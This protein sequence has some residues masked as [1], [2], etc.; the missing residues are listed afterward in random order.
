MHARA[1]R[2][3]GTLPRARA[4]PRDLHLPI[5]ALEGPCR[6]I[7]KLRRG[8]Q[9]DALSSD[10]SRLLTRRLHDFQRRHPRAAP[11]LRT[12]SSARN[13]E[14]GGTLIACA[15][16]TGW[17]D[18]YDVS[19]NVILSGLDRASH[20]DRIGPE[21]CAVPRVRRNKLRRIGG[22][23]RHS[24]LLTRSDRRGGHGDAAGG[25]LL[26][27]RRIER[28]PSR[29]CDGKK[30]AHDWRCTPPV[31]CRPISCDGIPINYR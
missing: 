19:T 3:A 12:V 1:A 29:N 7:L 24:I 25:S 16:R 4:R 21:R 9:S 6:L 17:S 8:L 30:T 10:D 23:P 20:G 15:A 22:T 27:G 14:R 26:R 28:D 5:A 13:R 2:H 31:G 18:F 11:E